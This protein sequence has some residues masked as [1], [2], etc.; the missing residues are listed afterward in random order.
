MGIACEISGHTPNSPVHTKQ[1]GPEQPGPAPGRKRLRLGRLAR[2]AHLANLARLAASAAHTRP[3]PSPGSG[4][5][6]SVPKP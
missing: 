6:R 2:L 3:E 4:F 1:P 5:N